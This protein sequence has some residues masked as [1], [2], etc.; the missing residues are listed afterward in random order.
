[1]IYIFFLNWMY[2]LRINDYNWSQAWSRKILERIDLA[3]NSLFVLP[4]IIVKSYDLG[5]RIKEI[6][7]IFMDRQVGVSKMSHRIIWEAMWMV[8]ALRLRRIP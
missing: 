7:I 5:F 8:W 2:K 6:P 4:E 1:M 3:S